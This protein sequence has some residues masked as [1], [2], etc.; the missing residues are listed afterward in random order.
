MISIII[1]IYNAERYIKECLD[2]IINQ[3]F[4]NWECILVDDGSI[5]KSLCICNEYAQNDDR[6]R[7]FH[8]ENSGVSVARNVGIDNAKGDWFFFSDAD[9]VL[10]PNA[11]QSLS[12]LCIDNRIDIVAGSTCKIVNGEIHFLTKLSSNYYPS[13]IG[14]MIHSALW[15]YIFRASIIREKHIR[16]EPGLAYSEDGVFMTTFAVYCNA[17]VTI[18]EFVY[19]YRIHGNSV[20]ANKDGVKKAY[21]Q[22]HAAHC[23]YNL[24]KSE[25]NSTKKKFLCEVYKK[26]ENWGF[27]AYAHYTIRFKRYGEYKRYYLEYFSSSIHLFVKTLIWTLISI[28]RKCFRSL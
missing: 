3:S 27:W 4:G 14:K 11:L 22:F 23:I 12:Q 24:Y 1:P 13:A 20:C 15:G 9:D 16:F 25:R 2:S 7:V 26:F 18:P 17:M 8:Q 5:D 28:K 21:H 6:F 19:A 10:F